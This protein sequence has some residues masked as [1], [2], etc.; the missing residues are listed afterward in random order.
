M[1]AFS[2]LGEMAENMKKA[3]AAGEKVEIRGVGVLWVKD[4]PEYMGRNPHTGEEIMVAPSKR[5]K[6][7]QS[8][9]MKAA[10]NG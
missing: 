6:F 10:L 9:V 7:R 3:L 4:I 1:A 2:V 8:T 5:V